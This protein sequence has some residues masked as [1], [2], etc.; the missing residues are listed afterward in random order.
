M[1]FFYAVHFFFHFYS[2][3]SIFIA[4]V[5]FIPFYDYILILDCLSASSKI[6]CPSSFHS[7][8]YLNSPINSIGTLEG[9]SGFSTIVLYDHNTFDFLITCLL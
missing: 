1:P 7:M 6:Y 5:H 2:I 4:F 9:V 8:F 3:S